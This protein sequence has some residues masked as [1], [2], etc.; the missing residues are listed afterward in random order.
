MN[1]NYLRNN[2][3]GE[4]FAQIEAEIQRLGWTQENIRGYLMATFNKRA[5]AL[6]TLEE[7]EKFLS[8]LRSI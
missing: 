7:G 4:I 8:Y 2:H 6:L 5:R 1:T 3:P